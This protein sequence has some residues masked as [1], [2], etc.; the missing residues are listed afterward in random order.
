M[1]NVELK[2]EKLSNGKYRKV[3]TCDLSKNELNEEIS[4]INLESAN[5]DK[6]IEFINNRKQALKK[7]KEDIDKVFN[8]SV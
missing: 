4:S 6:S 5:I 2:Y 7:Q 3:Y 8:E 1:E